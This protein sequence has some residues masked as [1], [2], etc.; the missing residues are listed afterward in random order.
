MGADI[1]LLSRKKLLITMKNHVLCFS[2][3]ENG[4]GIFCKRDREQCS[5]GNS[6]THSWHNNYNS[7]ESTVTDLS[8]NNFEKYGMKSRLKHYL[9]ILRS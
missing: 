8:A 5:F 7:H 6:C 1:E 2:M 9:G 4:T 3:E